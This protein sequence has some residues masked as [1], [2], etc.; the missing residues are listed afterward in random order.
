MF[1]LLAIDSAISTSA[2]YRL[3]LRKD[4]AEDVYM[5]L[6]ICLLP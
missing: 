2:G 6:A 4:F 3:L 1:E 5:P